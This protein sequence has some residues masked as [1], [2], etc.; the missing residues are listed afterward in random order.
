M[1]ALD[2]SVTR[3]QKQI[4]IYVLNQQFKYTQ[5]VLAELFGCAVPTVALAIKTSRALPPES[6][7][8]VI[9][10][11]Q[12]HIDTVHTQATAYLNKRTLGFSRGRV[13]RY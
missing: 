7:A 12:P 8:E 5:D 13:N 2:K 11:L 10:L 1:I 3:E 6:L 4:I 9:P